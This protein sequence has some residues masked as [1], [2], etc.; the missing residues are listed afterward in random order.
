[1]AEPYAEPLRM[2]TLVPLWHY[3]C[4]HGYDGIGPGSGRVR[5]G[6]ELINGEAP[7]PSSFVWLTDLAVPLREPLGLTSMLS[8]CDR[9]AHRYRVTNAAGIQRWVT[10]ARALPRQMREE[11]EAAPGARPTHWWVSL[12][13][14]PVVLDERQ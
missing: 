10:F 13:P 8:R 14:V 1:M 11:L 2:Q 9:T 3:T 6:A 5:P 4:R 7:W 12:A